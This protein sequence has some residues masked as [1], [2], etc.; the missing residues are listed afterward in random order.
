MYVDR[1]VSF[2]TL[3]GLLSTVHYYIR[4]NHLT[5]YDKTRAA[6]QAR[7]FG[8]PSGR[9]S[10]RTKVSKSSGAG[11]LLCSQVVHRRQEARQGGEII[12]IIIIIIIIALDVVQGRNRRG[13]CI[14]GL[15]IADRTGLLQTRLQ[16]S[17]VINAKEVDLWFSSAIVQMTSAVL[18]KDCMAMMDSGPCC[19]I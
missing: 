1:F 16:F 8:S 5:S 2:P 13:V 18:C 4:D 6:L 9:H 12:I 14:L 19:C 10:G 17:S 15:G 11:L 7:G 3:P